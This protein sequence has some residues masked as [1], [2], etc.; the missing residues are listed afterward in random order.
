[1]ESWDNINA[2][3]RMQSYIEAHLTEPIT[4]YMRPTGDMRKDTIVKRELYDEHIHGKFNIVAIFDDRACV[5]REVWDKLGFSDRLF[6]VGP[7]DRDD[8]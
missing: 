4:L 6:R 1:M 3:Q 2:V 5:N 8:F 7:I